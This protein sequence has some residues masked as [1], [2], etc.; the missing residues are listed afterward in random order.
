ML[1]RFLIVVL[2]VLPL[3]ACAQTTPVVLPSYETAA[4]AAV[5]IDYNSGQTLLS[6]DADLALPPASMS[7]LMTLNMIFE[8]LEDGRLTM[9]TKIPVSPHAASYG[10]STMFLD[11]RDR[12]RVEDIIRGII[13]LSGNDACAAIAEALSPDGTEPGF[14]AMMTR[15]AQELGMTSSRFA[16][17]S[18]WPAP[19]HVM[20]TRD[21]AILAQRLIRDFP[22]YYPYFAERVFEFDGRAPANTRNRN[23]LLRLDIG[24]DG[25]KTGH[26]NEAGY[27]LVG[28]A[29]Q[30]ERRVIF[31]IT[32][33]ETE[34]ARAREAEKVVNWAFRQFVEKEVFSGG[35]EVTQAGVFLGASRQVPLVTKAPLTLL[36]P[37]IGADTLEAEV[38]YDGP[39][40]APIAAGTEVAELTVSFAGMEPVTVPLVAQSD[41]AKAGIM[42][43]IQVAGRSL[44]EQ[45]LSEE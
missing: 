29:V 9:D 32:G 42:R 36:M 16:N 20:S 14:A 21:L 18:G 6:K 28:S 33:L 2:N 19:G 8:A 12:V 34:E 1:S 44:L 24:A 25:L 23:P 45:V 7:K 17:A 41:I 13:V 4:R 10:G 5:V 38:T 40:S 11:P 3:A 43:R 35:E 26:T 39:L 30:G 22:Q 27:G 15:R 31:V 37:A